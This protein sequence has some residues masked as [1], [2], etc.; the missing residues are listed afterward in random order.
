MTKLSLRLIAEFNYCEKCGKI[1]KGKETGCL[2]ICAECGQQN[3]D[4][5]SKELLRKLPEY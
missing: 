2:R 1:V 3:L 5:V 4:A